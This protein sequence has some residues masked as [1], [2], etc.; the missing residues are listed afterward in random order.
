MYL[1]AMMF[2]LDAIL[3]P[4]CSHAYAIVPAAVLRCIPS[5]ARRTAVQVTLIEPSGWSSVLAFLLACAVRPDAIALT[6]RARRNASLDNQPVGLPTG[7]CTA[8]CIAHQGIYL[9]THLCNC[10][11]FQA[12]SI[13]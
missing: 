6:V 7:I 10:L 8:T 1:M 3:H 12:G 11:D 2:K 13:E 5:W 9:T 4:Q